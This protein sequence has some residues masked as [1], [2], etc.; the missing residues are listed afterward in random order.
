M[1]QTT[2]VKTGGNQMKCKKRIAVLIMLIGILIA[3]TSS[4]TVS[5]WKIVPEIQTYQGTT[6]MK[7]PIEQLK[8]LPEEPDWETNAEAW[9]KFEEQRKDKEMMRKINDFIQEEVKRSESDAFIYINANE[10]VMINSCITADTVIGKMQDEVLYRSK[11]NN[12]VLVK[13]D[14]DGII[15]RKEYFTKTRWLNRWKD[16]RYTVSTEILKDITAHWQYTKGKLYYLVKNS[17][18]WKKIKVAEGN[19]LEGICTTMNGKITYPLI[20]RDGKLFCYIVENVIPND[21]AYY[22]QNGIQITEI[23][24]QQE[25]G[26]CNVY[27]Y[28]DDEFHIIAK[29]DSY[30]IDFI[31]EA[32]DIS[33]EEKQDF[34]ICYQKIEKLGYRESEYKSFYYRK[35][36]GSPIGYF[37]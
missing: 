16:E 23:D 14:N 32:S 13:I 22:V 25:E 18:G 30:K 37:Y 35:K 17:Q 10:D 3:G 28:G 1:Y 19:L 8:Q 26:I 11:Q 24:F 5:V 31:C 21:Y 33:L 12:L 20:E 27:K 4:E 36:N 7:F 6:Y 34:S 2:T 15:R 29:I 9:E